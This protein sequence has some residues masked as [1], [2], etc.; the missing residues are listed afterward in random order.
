MQMMVM[1]VLR[2][3]MMVMIRG[4][5]GYRGGWIFRKCDVYRIRNRWSRATFIWAFDEFSD[6]GIDGT[7]LILIVGEFKVYH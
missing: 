7:L 6:V 1:W 2:V 5:W 3:M 4:H